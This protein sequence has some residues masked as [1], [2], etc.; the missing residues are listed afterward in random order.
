MMTYPQREFRHHA[1]C[2]LTGLVVLML[3]STLLPFITPS[4]LGREP[5][6]SLTLT[7]DSGSCDTALMATGAGFVAGTTVTIFAG[8]TP[9]DEFG[10]IARATVAADGRFSVPVPI[11]MFLPGCRGG[12]LPTT[13]GQ[14]Y[15]VGAMTG[16]GPKEGDD[17]REPSAQ[18]VFTRTFSSAD[19]FRLVWQRTDLAVANGESDET[20]TWGPTPLT[21][22][23]QERYDDSPGGMRDVQYF[24]KSRMEINDPA[25][26]ADSVWFV[27]NGLLVVE[28]VEGWVQTG[29]AE[30]DTAPD[31]AAINIAGDPADETGVGPTY[32]DINTFGLRAKPATAVGTAL[33]SRID[34][35]GTITTDASLAT[36]GVTAARRVTVPGIDHTVAAVFWE[37]MQA[38]GQDYDANPFYVTGYPLTE[39]YWSTVA[40]EGSAHD[41][42]WQCFERR[43]LT[44]TPANPDGWQVEFGNIGQHYFTWRYPGEAF[45]PPTPRS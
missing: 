18:A 37:R 38:I 2:L 27:T 24:D 1:W 39:A 42:L 25:G 28:M 15:V 43:C 8:P 16:A 6:A 33:T 23:F 14:R 12:A 7:P 41:V 45:P 30:F 3:L 19:Y 10:V 26:D 22:V 21:K 29:D 13:D 5:G 4:A 34:G 36:H 40:V 32:A 31:P 9:G 11:E 44:Y 20:W 17:W 35:A